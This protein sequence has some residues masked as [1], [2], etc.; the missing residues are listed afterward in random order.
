MTR[1]GRDRSFT[2]AIL[3]AALFYLILVQG[4]P[5]LWA[6]FVSF[7]DQ[8]I[9][10][11]GNFA[12]G[13]N[14]LALLSD[15]TYWA[16]IYFT[17]L[18]VFA[19][20]LFKLVFGFIMASM[21]HQPLRGRGFFRALLFLPW[22]LPTLT[23]VLAWRWMLGD[24]GGI[25]NYLL[26]GLKVVSRPV[27]WL[28]DPVLARLSVVAVNIWRG[29]PFFGISILAGLQSI[30]PE[31]YEVAKIDGANAAKRFLHVTIPGVRPIVLLV[32]LISTIW[33]LG[34]FAIIWLMTRGGPA[35][36]TQVFS[37]LSYVVT[38]QNLDLAKGIAVALTI[39]PLSLVL[40]V[41]T[42]RFIFRREEIA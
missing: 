24:I 41:V 22:A 33:T 1:S 20:I 25:V 23:S 5:F 15:S 38:F 26:M 13:G 34:D 3:V 28:G 11:P 12:G 14:F 37:T 4:Y 31:L 2:I 42:M 17:G 30:S 10:R 35:N 16:A 18:Y 9:G 8:R 6:L 39:V 29:T 36:S 19:A 32:T 21:L 7:T 27:G 40:M